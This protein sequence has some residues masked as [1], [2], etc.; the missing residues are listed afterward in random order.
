MVMG[1]EG[2]SLVEHFG[3]WEDPRRAQGRWHN[4]LDSWL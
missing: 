1:G 3:S 4:L 2:T